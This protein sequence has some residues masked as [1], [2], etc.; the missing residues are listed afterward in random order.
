MIRYWGW[1]VTWDEPRLGMIRYWGWSVTGDDPLLGMIRYW[2]WS[3]TGDDPLL[4]TIRYRG[5]SVTGDD[6]LLGMIRR[7]GHCIIYTDISDNVYITLL[8]LER[9]SFS[10]WIVNSSITH[11]SVCS[12]LNPNMM[13]PMFYEVGSQQLNTNIYVSVLFMTRQ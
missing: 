10:F 7:G 3:V 6:P 11:V 9:V 4:G 8:R 12:F 13:L 2:G 1:F 5:W